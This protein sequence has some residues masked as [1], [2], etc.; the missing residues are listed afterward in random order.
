MTVSINSNDDQHVKTA[1][2]K[3][4]TN[5]L[6]HATQIYQ[7]KAGSTNVKFT[8]FNCSRDRT[9]ENHAPLCIILYHRWSQITEVSLV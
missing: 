3:P 5:Y 1:S 7:S 2:L 8:I 6:L 9:P 4:N